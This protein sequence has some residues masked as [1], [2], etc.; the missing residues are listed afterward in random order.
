MKK[1]LSAVLVLVLTSIG[2]K[3]FA[4]EVSLKLSKSSIIV[5]T[6]GSGPGGNGTV[7]NAKSKVLNGN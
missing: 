7:R 3:S 6:D 2:A 5:A 1:S 4:S